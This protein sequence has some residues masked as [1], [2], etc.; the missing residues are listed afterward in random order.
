MILRV[1]GTSCWDNKRALG[2]E[3]RCNRSLEFVMRE[4]NV[5][6]VP[7][8]ELDVKVSYELTFS[9]LCEVVLAR[10]RNQRSSHLV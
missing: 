5:N 3:G 7:N 1:R 9:V 6:K 2:Q 4:V 10:V 8:A